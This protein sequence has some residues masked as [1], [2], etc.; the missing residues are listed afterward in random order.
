MAEELRE[1]QAEREKL[2]QEVATINIQLQPHIE[3]SNTSLSQIYTK[4]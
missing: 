4:T 3:N 1:L 2:E